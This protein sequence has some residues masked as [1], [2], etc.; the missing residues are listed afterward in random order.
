MFMR[1]STRLARVLAVGVALSLS[2]CATVTRGTKQTWT[3]NTEPGGASVKT[4][5]GFNCAQ[6]PCTF[7]IKRK[8]NFDVTIEKAGYKTW[9]GQVKHQ[10][11]GG[12][13]ATT[14]AGNAILGGLVGLGVDAASGATQELK[15]NPLVV[16]LEPDTPVPPAGAPAP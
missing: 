3:V 9:T 12:G 8:S 1:N 10:T 15:P 5:V 7:K 6:T 14:V 13:V 16:K 4:T 11:A 2:A